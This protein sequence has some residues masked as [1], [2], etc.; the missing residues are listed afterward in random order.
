MLAV[1]RRYQEAAAHSADSL[2]IR[3]MPRQKF[4]VVRECE[5]PSQIARAV[6][7]FAA[8]HSRARGPVLLMGL[9]SEL[10]E[11][12]ALLHETVEDLPCR[13]NLAFR[14][15]RLDYVGRAENWAV[16]SGVS[17]VPSGWS[18]VDEPIFFVPTDPNALWVLLNWTSM[19]AGFLAQAPLGLVVPRWTAPATL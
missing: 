15:G 19:P 8:W 10:I 12:W 3:A 2:R 4:M 16:L 5:E 17:T 18:M 11:F 7:Y 14:D 9:P 13:R 1:V 6:L